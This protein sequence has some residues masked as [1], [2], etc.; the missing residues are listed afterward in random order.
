M[1]GSTPPGELRIEIGSGDF[2]TPGYFHIDAWP[3]AKDLEAIAQ[4][5]RLPLPDGCAREVRAVHS[6]EHV[7]PPRLLATL[8]EWRRVLRPGGLVHVSVPNAPAIMAAF[9]KASVPEKWPLIGSLL[10][11]YVTL[12]DREPEALKLR[13][14]HQIVFDRDLLAWALE[15]AGFRD[16][17]DRTSEVEDRHTAGWAAMVEHYSLIMEATSPGL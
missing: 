4:M 3:W 11:M 12:A 16:V 15:E 10:G 5:W 8:R 14:D 7:E 13:S 6:L 17:A 1:L 9:N 2:P